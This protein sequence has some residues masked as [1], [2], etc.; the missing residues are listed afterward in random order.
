MSRCQ[1]CDEILNS[2]E[3]TV[4]HREN[5]VFLDMCSNCIKS[6]D[7]FI[8]LDIRHDLISEGDT[9]VV[10][11]ERDSLEESDVGMHCVER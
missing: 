7:V 9:N 6:I 1:S 8:P 10:E 5:K 3:T 4:K 11:Y 2:F